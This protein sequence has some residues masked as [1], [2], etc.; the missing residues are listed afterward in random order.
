MFGNM[1]ELRVASF[2]GGTQMKKRV[3]LTDRLVH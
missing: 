3:R 1:W 2:T